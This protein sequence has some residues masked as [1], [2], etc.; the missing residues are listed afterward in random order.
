MMQHAEK[1]VN[2]LYLFIFLAV[3]LN[4]S[5]LWVTVIGPDGALY[6][7]I[8]KNMV[9]NHNYMDLFVE[10]R[11]WLDKPHFPFW[12]AAFSF[13]L[14]G[15]SS[16]AYKLP[17]VLFI[18]LGAWYC[19]RLACQLYNREIALWSVLILLTA[20]HLVLSNMDVRAEPYLTGLIIASVYHFYRALGKNWFWHLLAGAVFAA[21]AVMTKGIFA[22]IPVWGAIAGHLLIT[23]QWG[24]LFNLRWLVA[25]VLILVFMLPEL[26][27]LYV[28][29]DAHPEKLVFGRNHVSG[30]KFFFWDSQFGRFFNSGP[31]KKASGDPFF[32]VHTTL[33]AFLPWALLLFAGLFV[34]I[35]KHWGRAQSAE[36]FTLCGAGSTFLIFS[37]SK[38]QLPHYI[39]IIFPFF[40]I[41]TAVFIIEMKSEKSIKIWKSIQL[42]VAV[43]MLMLIACLHWFFRPDLTT[44]SV[45]L[46]LI[47]AAI[48]FI[49]TWYYPAGSRYKVLFQCAAVALIVNLYFNT[50]YYPKL[51]SYQADSTA[52]FYINHHNTGK[53]PVV[54]MVNGYAYAID[55]YTEQP[56]H[57]Y[58]LGEEQS[59]PPR[60]FLLYGDSDLLQAAA[61]SGLKGDTVQTFRRY[62]ITRIKGKFLNHQT[63]EETLQSS[64]LILIK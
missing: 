49:T 9:F 44:T 39:T 19:Y 60:P 36:W 14:F 63:R 50:V 38:F 3:L 15:I 31:I 34:F 18:M 35:K 16:W 59:L 40:A 11:D 57:Y 32:F 6:A 12:M 61:A 29:F 64:Q 30:L 25:A 54:K 7:S 2:W 43:L 55:L 17:G 58:R 22:L 26:Y 33:W 1:T 48:L 41:L 24:L 56:L 52:A 10:G 13:K 21:C 51:T 53:I 42:I 45:V 28:Q 20:Q 8:A 47:G 46:L 62:H 4:F 5:G 27:S 23:R 37:L